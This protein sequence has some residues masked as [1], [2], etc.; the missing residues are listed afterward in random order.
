MTS[1]L[2]PIQEALILNL[3]NCLL[4]AVTDRSNLKKLSLPEAVRAAVKGGATMIQL[5]E[6]ELSFDEFTASAREVG[7]VCKEYGVP[8]IINDNIEVCLAS[9]AD[10]VHLGQGDAPLFEA[11]KIL[12]QNKIIGITAK[13]VEQARLAE[14]DG[15]DYIGSGA[16]FGTSTKRDAV[17]M[18]L[19]TL[20]E[21]CSSVNIPVA[22]IGGINRENARLLKG[23]GISGI[24]VAS[25]I[26]ALDDIQAAA[27]ELLKA[28]KETVKE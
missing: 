2:I 26:F 24:A 17:K 18:E 27:E 15:A 23:S 5:R 1:L 7:A 3:C 8:L 11:R 20:K 14:R 16:V 6:K 21:I 13:T 25:G 22:A 19:S 28:A 12:G 9:G 4:Y 10:G